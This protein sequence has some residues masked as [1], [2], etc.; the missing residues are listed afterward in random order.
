MYIQSVRHT[1]T[2]DAAGSSGMFIDAGG[3]DANGH[4]QRRA[5]EGARSRESANVAKDT[6]GDAYSAGSGSNGDPQASVVG[7]G[8]VK[9]ATCKGCTCLDACA[10]ENHE[11]GD[12]NRD[13]S[14]DSRRKVTNVSASKLHY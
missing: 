8:W 14:Q 4:D 13:L 11:D 3:V 6:K 7:F 5:E 9:T 12:H 2:G 1:D 10:S